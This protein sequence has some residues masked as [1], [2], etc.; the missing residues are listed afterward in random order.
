M[1]D[2]EARDRDSS[3][4][5]RG[6]PIGPDYILGDLL[7]T[8]G[9]GVVYAATQRSRA[10]MVAIKLPRAELVGDAQLL[11]RFRSEAYAGSRVNHRNVVRVVD[12][13]NSASAPYLVM[14]YVAGPRLGQLVIDN[15]PMPDAM[16]VDIVRQI[17]AGL[18][19]AHRCGIVHA[20]VKSDN[21]LVE[22]LSDGTVVP[23]LIDFGIARFLTDPPGPPG[24][25]VISG[26]PEYLA[27]EVICGGAPTFGSDVYGAGV[28]LYELVT[29]ATPFAGGGSAKV[30]S[31]KLEGEAVP[32][33]WRCPDL[34]IPAD[35]DELVMRALARD[36]AV[37]FTD[38]AELGRALDRVKRTRADLGAARVRQQTSRGAFSTEATTATISVESAPR[39]RPVPATSPIAMRRRAVLECIV[40]GDVDAIAIAYL[41]LARAL[42]DEHQLSAAITELEQGVE[43][44]SVPSGSAPV[45]RILLTLSALHDGNGDR[46]R[47]R[48]L[49]NAAREHATRA[50]SAIGTERAERLCARLARPRA[51][52]RS[53]RPW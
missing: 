22:T 21:I 44:L 25:A 35:L 38:A 32:M 29:G 9:M 1:D 15:G 19:A 28:I 16:A 10:R 12:F 31:S 8:G 37:R 26:T 30:M 41:D 4:S 3:P 27:P 33:S 48:L 6:D 49:A 40:T 2:D 45:W 53:S 51:S 18:E 52:T 43:L 20:D 7:G 17:V 24:E 11:G 34:E 47:A 50:G 36:P 42:V 39:M 5:R 13:G 23:R 46:P 14:E